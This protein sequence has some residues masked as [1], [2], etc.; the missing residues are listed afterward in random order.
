MSLLN[1]DQKNAIIDILKEQCLCIQKSNAMERDMFP[2]LYD[3][4]YMS[5]VTIRILL[6]CT[7]DFKRI[8]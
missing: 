4:Q 3:A 7:L 6:K 1:D 8:P 2:N 5:V